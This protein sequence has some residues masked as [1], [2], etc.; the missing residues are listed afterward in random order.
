MLE[1]ERKKQWCPQARP[2]GDYDYEYGNNRDKQG[3]PKA[4]CLCIGRDCAL[5]EAW[6]VAEHKTKPDCWMLKSNLERLSN[7][8][9]HKYGPYQWHGQCGLITKGRDHG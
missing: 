4:N 5:F 1:S 3:A 2:E 7:G 6:E 9:R 8:Q